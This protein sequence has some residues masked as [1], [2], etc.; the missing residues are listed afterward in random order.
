MTQYA[1]GFIEWSEVDESDWFLVTLENGD[2][3]PAFISFMDYQFD[4]I[5]EK[6][7]AFS[8]LPSGWKGSGDDNG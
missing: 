5:Q 8:K 7:I 2:V 3:M 6:V 4:T 1:K